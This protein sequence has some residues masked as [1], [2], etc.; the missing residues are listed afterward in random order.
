MVQA[1]NAF[2]VTLRIV[3]GEDNYLVR[4]GIT[5]VL[6]SSNSGLEVVAAVGSKESVLE[7]VEVTGPDV[8][9][10]DIRMPPSGRAE[11]IEI[12]T[13]LRRLHPDIGVV[14]LSQYNDVGYA[15]ALLEPGAAGRAYLLKERIHDRGQLVGAVEAVRAGGSVVDPKVVEALIKADAGSEH[16]RLK[17]LTRRELEVL[18]EIARG[19]SNVAIAQS[20]TITKR[21]VEGYVNSIFWK[22]G[23]AESPDLSKRVM[24]A[25]LLLSET[26]AEPLRREGPASE[27]EDRVQSDDQR[28]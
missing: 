27:L 1:R 11:G 5:R 3:L 24:A 9:V 2:I 4:E 21:A 19:K 7:A 20:L 26:G 10:T 15:L 22:L 13:T 25:L 14:V 28:G 17:N 6:A 12:A 16:G 18:G 23:L 8:V